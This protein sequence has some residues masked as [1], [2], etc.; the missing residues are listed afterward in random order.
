MLIKDL[1]EGQLNGLSIV[2]RTCSV[3]S[4]IGIAFIVTT[5][6]LSRG[7]HK[8]INRLIF[9]ASVGN[10]GTNIG[11]IISRAPIDGASIT[12]PHLCQFQAFLIQM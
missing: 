9:Y 8:P 11:T 7:F 6:L 12:H 10:L 5:F 1:T 4:L 2:E 3:L